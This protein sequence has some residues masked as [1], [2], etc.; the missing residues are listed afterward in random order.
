MSFLV[1]AG[2]HQCQIRAGTRYQ[3]GPGL[4]IRQ[5]SCDSFFLATMPFCGPTAGPLPMESLGLRATTTF[6]FEGASC[7]ALIK[8][9]LLRLWEFT[10]MQ[11]SIV[12]FDSGNGNF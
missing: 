8:H 3:K 10:L 6:K 5:L 12:P 4:M 11:S 1:G 9:L 2:D 7:L